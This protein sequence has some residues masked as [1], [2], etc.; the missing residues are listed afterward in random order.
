MT[1][2]L[3]PSNQILA[4]VDTNQE[5]FESYRCGRS[6]EESANALARGHGAHLGPGSVSAHYPARGQLQ[7]A[8]KHEPAL[9]IARILSQRRLRKAATTRLLGSEE[10]YPGF[11]VDGLPLRPLALYRLCDY[12]ASQLI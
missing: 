1:L 6:K 5:F 7:K 4:A 10:G 11:V 9:Q 3:G 2:K 12:V 8:G